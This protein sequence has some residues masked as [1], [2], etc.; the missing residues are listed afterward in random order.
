M[1][2]AIFIRQNMAKWHNYEREFKDMKSLSPDYLAEAYGEL[3]GDLA[4]AQTH[5]PNSTITTY[6]NSITAQLHQQI[7]SS[8]RESASRLITFW[9]REL[10]LAMWQARRAM[11]LSLVIFLVAVAVGAFSAYF[12]PDFVRLVL[13]DEYV[14]RSI[15][16]VESGNPMGIYGD[17]PEAVMYFAIT[18]NNIKVAFFAFAAGLLTSIFTAYIL[19]NNGVILGAWL[20]FFFRY[21]LLSLSLTTIMLHGTLELSA[22]IIAGGAG[23]V[24]GNGWLFP[25][26]YSRLE[27]FKRSA[28]RGTKI[29][30][31]VVPLLM[32]AG[33]IESFI[34][35]HVEWPLWVRA[36]IIGVSALVVLFYYVF[37]PWWVAHHEGKSAA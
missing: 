35:R 9:T 11:F 37:Y 24:M 16:N 25:G 23:I 27:S 29:V 4:F 17:T 3:T 7:Y 10:P 1:K 32:V 31:G 6:L 15:E 13:S 21:G 22:I 28:K 12:E 19:F 33:F 2:E 18:Y 8:K 36:S 30:L 5:Y 20:V 34:T 26:T 14:E